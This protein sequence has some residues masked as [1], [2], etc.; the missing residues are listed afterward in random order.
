LAS[1]S[2]RWILG[3]AIAFPTI[4]VK[5]LFAI[6]AGAVLL[7]FIGIRNAWDIVTFIAIKG[8]GKPPS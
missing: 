8:I 2:E 4:P 7:I 6:A 5:A 1:R 3:G